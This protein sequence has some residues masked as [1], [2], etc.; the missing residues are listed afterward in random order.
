[1]APTDGLG[2]ERTRHQDPF[3]SEQGPWSLSGRLHKVEDG[4]GSEDAHCTRAE[5]L[6]SPQ[7]RCRSQPGPSADWTLL[8]RSRKGGCLSGTQSLPRAP[9][10]AG[11]LVTGHPPQPRRLA[12][13]R[14][15]QAKLLSAEHL[16][17]Q[18]GRVPAKVKLPG[19]QQLDGVLVTPLMRLPGSPSVLLLGP[20]RG[21][22]CQPMA[23][24]VV[25]VVSGVS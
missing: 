8:G 7:R 11:C 22:Q 23:A 3:C 15:L 9:G 2:F 19:G 13:R 1:M 25:S 14:S 16:G 6:R 4:L 18:A 10:A 17:L 20:P 5:V 24:A 12:G 21:Q